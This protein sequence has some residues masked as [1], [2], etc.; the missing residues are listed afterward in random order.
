MRKTLTEHA[1]NRAQ[2]A[3][4]PAPER[5][6]EEQTEESARFEKA[7]ASVHKNFGGAMRRLSE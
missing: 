6:A 4:T 5:R 3:D 1:D 2:P 7:L